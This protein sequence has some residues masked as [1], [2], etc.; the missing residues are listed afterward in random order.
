MKKIGPIN[1]LAKRKEI[2]IIGL[3]REYSDTILYVYLFILPHSF[4]KY[5]INM[6]T[7]YENRNRMNTIIA[8]S[9]SV[10]SVKIFTFFSSILKTNKIHNSWI[11][12]STFAG[13]SFHSSEIVTKV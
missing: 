8:S 5:R 9:N 4:E 12:I 10:N 11:A 2:K 6:N 1:T 13:S 7:A 3:D